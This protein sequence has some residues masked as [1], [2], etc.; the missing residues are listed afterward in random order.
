MLR[1]LSNDIIEKSNLEL[2]NKQMAI[3]SLTTYLK[4]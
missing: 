3:D 1:D 2:E 4:Y